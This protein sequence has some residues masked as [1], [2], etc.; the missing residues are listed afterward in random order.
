[1][2]IVRVFI[3]MVLLGLVTIT[4]QRCEV[5]LLP[6]GYIVLHIIVQIIGGIVFGDVIGNRALSS[7]QNERE[8]LI[9]MELEYSEFLLS[10]RRSMMIMSIQQR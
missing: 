4:E 6:I 10:S 2:S 8:L 9:M 1:M 3:L 5:Y 7:I